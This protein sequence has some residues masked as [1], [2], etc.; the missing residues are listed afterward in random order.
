MKKWQGQYCPIKIMGQNSSPPHCP[1]VYRWTYHLALEC[2]ELC[3]FPVDVSRSRSLF[4]RTHIFPYRHSATGGVADD[5]IDIVF[6]IPLHETHSRGG[7]RV[8]GQC[9]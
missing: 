3:I 8:F 1:N 4:S 6:C 2:T 9:S 5:D 7:W